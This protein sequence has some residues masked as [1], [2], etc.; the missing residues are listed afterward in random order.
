MWFGWVQL[1]SL[2]SD[3]PLIQN[4]EIEAKT[5]TP[6]PQMTLGSF[7]KKKKDSEHFVSDVGAS[8]PLKQSIF[9]KGCYHPKL[10]ATCLICIGLILVWSVSPV[11]GWGLET[12][13][14]NTCKCWHNS[15]DNHQSWFGW[16][17][18]CIYFLLLHLRDLWSH[19]TFL[20]RLILTSAENPHCPGLSETSFEKWC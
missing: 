2:C 11:L 18:L 3:V 1:K 15:F 20:T 17:A 9:H 5:S 8:H 7:E 6:P 19:D 16:Q 10:S 12:C 14:I 13:G 4:S